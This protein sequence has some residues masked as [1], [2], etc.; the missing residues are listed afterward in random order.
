MIRQPLF[1]LTPLLFTLLLIGC[2]SDPSKDSDNPGRFVPV[3]PSPPR[4]TG[5]LRLEAQL[6]GRYVQGIQIQPE[7]LSAIGPGEEIAITFK[8]Q[9]MQAIGQFDLILESRPA[10]RFD[11]DS[12][13]FVPEPPFVTLPPGIEEQDDGQ[14]RF[15]GV[16]FERSTSGDAELGTLRLQTPADFSD[17]NPLHLSVVFFSI[18]PSST[19]RDSY[20]AEE[21]QLG[22][23]V[24]GP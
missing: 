15:I 12:S 9:G 11:M 19:E 4:A 14:V 16:N 2:E 8:A 23:V 5:E 10:T 21:L 20:R 3:D 22:I 17:Q 6:D 1:A 24:N 13:A 7:D 18:G